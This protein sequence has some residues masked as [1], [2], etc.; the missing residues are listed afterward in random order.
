MKLFFNLIA[1]VIISF[2]ILG[3]AIWMVPSTA[4]HTAP[5]VV[6]RYTTSIPEIAHMVKPGDIIIDTMRNPIMKVASVS[7]Q[8]L[9]S[10]MVMPSGTIRIIDNPQVW[11]ITFKAVPLHE[12]LIPKF[13]IGG[14]VYIE[15]PRWRKL[16]R[17]I[18]MEG[19]Q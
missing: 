10:A 15:T 16:V 5:T 8:S 14:S 19:E 3:L 1:A 2:M 12:G 17:V 4:G 6:F 13:V 9:K 18:E 11:E 7:V